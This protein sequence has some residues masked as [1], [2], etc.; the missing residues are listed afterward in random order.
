MCR[1]VCVCVQ[2]GADIAARGCVCLHVG[3]DIAAK[4][5]KLMQIRISLFLPYYFSLP[6]SL[7]Q[8]SI[9]LPFLPLN[10][11][12]INNTQ[13]YNILGIILGANQ[14]NNKQILHK[15]QTKGMF[16]KLQRTS[17]NFLFDF[18]LYQSNLIV[19]MHPFSSFKLVNAQSISKEQ[20]QSAQ[21]LHQ[22]N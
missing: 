17:F 18:L 14:H 2:G 19:A 12:L 1:G 22:L 11:N 20:H 16:H 9:L 21:K 13:Y 7:F 3:A 6:C 8:V 10:Q 4:I 5:V 15:E